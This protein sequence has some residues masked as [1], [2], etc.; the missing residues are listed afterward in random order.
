MTLALQPKSR[1]KI[2]AFW[3]FLNVDQDY[4]TVLYKWPNPA[5]LKRLATVLGFYIGPATSPPFLLKKSQIQII[6]KATRVC[7]I[8]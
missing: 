8:A 1:L 3:R 4:V 7:P 6:I 5:K 2:A